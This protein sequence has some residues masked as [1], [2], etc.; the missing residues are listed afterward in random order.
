MKSY[1]KKV[2]IS[3]WSKQYEVYKLINIDYWNECICIG[4]NSEHQEDKK[5]NK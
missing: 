1:I 3:N 4:R 2:R 5:D